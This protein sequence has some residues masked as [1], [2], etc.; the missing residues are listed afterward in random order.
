MKKK[1]EADL[2]S[3]AHRV[4]KLKGRE[5]VVKLHIEAQNLYEKLSI[6]RFY[7]ENINVLSKEISAEELE[8]KLEAVKPY[9]EANPKAKTIDT[10]EAEEEIIAETNQPEKDVEVE[11]DVLLE[12]IV[13]ET[14]EEVLIENE[15]FEEEIIEKETAL[16][17]NFN[18]NFGFSLDEEVEDVVK[19]E[20]KPKTL[21]DY[22]SDSYKDLEFIKIEDVPVEETKA[23]DLIFDEIEEEEEKPAQE[24]TL[25]N[26][27]DNI[28]SKPTSLNDTLIKGINI[29]LNDKIAFVKHLF[30]GSNEDFNRVISQ[31]STFNN[32]DE[33]NSFIDDLVKPDYNNWVGKEDY[34]ERFTQIVEKNFM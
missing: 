20:P 12:E 6:L 23:S 15:V 29:G 30:G 2:I 24:L 25:N 32:L 14:I 21:E 10:V 13:V 16:E 9:K 31:I 19:E 22:L 26:I 7:E 18:P 17:N 27:F 33:A 28:E 1:L 34:A 3:I 11:K 5:D 8:E 4:L